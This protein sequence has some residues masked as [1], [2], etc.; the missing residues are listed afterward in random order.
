MNLKSIKKDINNIKKTMGK[1]DNP[2]IQDFF[3]WCELHYYHR[4]VSIAELWFSEYRRGNQKIKSNPRLFLLLSDKYFRQIH[5]TDNPIKDGNIRLGNFKD[6]L[7][8]HWFKKYKP[9]EYM[10]PFNWQDRI[11]DPDYTKW[12]NAK[13]DSFI[14]S[15][16]L[17]VFNEI[18]EDD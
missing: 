1:N 7:Q 11:N 9:D 4:P 2:T 3:K 13:W 8:S 5:N 15:K 18:F 17:S 6:I 12:F 14:E 16:D 10:K